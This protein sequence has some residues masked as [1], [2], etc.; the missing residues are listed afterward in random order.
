[1]SY[2]VMIAGSAWGA[3]LEIFSLDVVVSAQ[4][5]RLSKCERA[6]QGS[7]CTHLRSTHQGEEIMNRLE[8]SVRRDYGEGVNLH[9]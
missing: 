1:M 9:Y 3:A 8:T 4:K 7:F 6:R 5:Q 2:S